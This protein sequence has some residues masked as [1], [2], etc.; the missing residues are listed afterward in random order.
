MEAKEEGNNGG[1]KARI[2]QTENGVLMLP[3]YSLEETHPEQDLKTTAQM[4]SSSH[5]KLT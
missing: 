2:Q 1:A 4:G 3:L 5:M